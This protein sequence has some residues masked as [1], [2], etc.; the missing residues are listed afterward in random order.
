[1]NPPTAMAVHPEIMAVAHGHV[2]EFADRIVD[3]F[4][5]GFVELGL[6]HAEEVT[7]A[8]AGEGEIKVQIDQAVD[9]ADEADGADDLG[10]VAFGRRKRLV[11]RGCRLSAEGGLAAE[12]GFENIRDGTVDVV[13]D[14]GFGDF[15]G[16]GHGE[17]GSFL[18]RFLLYR[19]VSH[20]V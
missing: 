6:G 7:G 5:A 15:S 12:H 14:E 2:G 13:A 18:P 4:V 8:D 11:G 3:H 10:A 9:I 19:P 16:S 1:M 20:R 17:K